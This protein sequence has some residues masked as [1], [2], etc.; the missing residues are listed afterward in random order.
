MGKIF[1]EG[2]INSKV[3]SHKILSD[4]IGSGGVELND[5]GTNTNKI[6]VGLSSNSKHTTNPTEGSPQTYGMS[7]AGGASGDKD[8]GYP[9]TGAGVAELNGSHGNDATRKLAF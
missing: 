8:I 6:G 9:G 5:F 4:D 1:T 2:F 7:N 3:A